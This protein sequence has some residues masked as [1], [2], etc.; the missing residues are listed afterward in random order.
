MFM[1]TQGYALLSGPS[2]PIIGVGKTEPNDTYLEQ[3]LDSATAAVNYLVERGVS[4]RDRIAIGGHSYGA[5]T[6][7]NLLAH[8]NLFCAGIAPQRR[9]QS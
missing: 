7:A 3:L 9:V 1:L 4:D 5:F 2:M 8:S 6:T